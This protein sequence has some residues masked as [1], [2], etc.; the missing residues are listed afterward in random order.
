[1][2]QYG[3]TC[4]TRSLLFRSLTKVRKVL[5]MSNDTVMTV[6]EMR[7][8]FRNELRHWNLDA[9]RLHRGMLRRALPTLLRD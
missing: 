7:F 2:V 4:G 9:V 5:L 1:M 3:E 8:N 6:T